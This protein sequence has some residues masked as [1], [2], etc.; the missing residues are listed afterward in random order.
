M[1]TRELTGCWPNGSLQAVQRLRSTVR[2]PVLAVAA[3]VLVQAALLAVFSGMPH[4]HPT[5]VTTGFRILAVGAVGGFVADSVAEHGHAKL[6]AAA[7]AVAGVVVG[8]TLWWLILYGETVGVFHHIHYALATTTVLL[9][10][11]AA[12]PRLVVAGVSL[13]VAATLTVGGLVGGRAARAWP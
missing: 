1:P 7:G 10:P 4:H 3:G 6:G 13:L 8:A 9:D 5:T 2:R 11:A 12:A